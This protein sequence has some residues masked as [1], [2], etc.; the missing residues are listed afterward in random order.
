MTLG[1]RTRQNSKCELSL[2]QSELNN[3]GT[4]AM[5][6]SQTPTGTS[7]LQIRVPMVGMGGL[8]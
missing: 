1:N 3:E 4:Y 6:P 2:K 7:S 8:V 5:V